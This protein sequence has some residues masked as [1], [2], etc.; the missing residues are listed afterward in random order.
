MD[1]APSHC[2][3]APLPL[4]QQVKT[5]IEARIASGQWPPEMKIPSENE[6]VASLGVS[7]MTVNR[8]LRELAALGHLVR[9]Q[10]VGTFVATPKPQ[11]ALLEIRSIA[12]EIRARGGRHT[13]RRR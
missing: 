13:S 12:D 1:V 6:L 2:R 9:V 7:R 5:Y 10:G 11:S 4:Y 8:A 3:S